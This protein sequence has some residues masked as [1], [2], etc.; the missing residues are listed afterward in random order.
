MYALFKLI[1]VLLL[2]TFTI[3]L[4]AQDIITETILTEYS[5]QSGIGYQ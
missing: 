3:C 4:F 2:L 1:L 5:L